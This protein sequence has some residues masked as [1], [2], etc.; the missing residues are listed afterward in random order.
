MQ[1]K[2][3]KMFPITFL[4]NIFLVPNP[5]LLLRIFR[6][7]YKNPV[8]VLDVFYTITDEMTDD[9]EWYTSFF[10]T[11]SNCNTGK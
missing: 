9:S 1:F 7:F 4:A 2:Q 5:V 11:D 6:H 8:L 3:K 10:R